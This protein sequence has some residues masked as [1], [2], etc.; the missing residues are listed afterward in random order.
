MND[1]FNV[2]LCNLSEQE[3]KKQFRTLT[4]TR[5]FV[6]NGVVVTSQT[7][8]VVLSGTENKKHQEHELWFVTFLFLLLLLQTVSMC[9]SRTEI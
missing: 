2:I 6:I 5:K 4:K 3:Q 1:I 8:R 7:S 9:E